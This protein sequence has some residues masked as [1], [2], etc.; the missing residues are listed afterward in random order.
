MALT[1]TNCNDLGNK[2]YNVSYE[3]VPHAVVTENNKFTPCV[4]WTLEFGVEIILSSEKY[5][6]FCQEKLGSH[7]SIEEK[8][9]SQPLEVARGPVGLVCRTSAGW[10]R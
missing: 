1:R 5:Y 10:S 8:I 7:N 6:A 3:F 2:H 4:V 9:Q